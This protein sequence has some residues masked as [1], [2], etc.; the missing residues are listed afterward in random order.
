MS[1]TC[2]YTLWLDMINV[3]AIKDAG[4]DPDGY[5]FDQKLID[6]TQVFARCWPHVL[7]V[8][9]SEDWLSVTTPGAFSKM[10]RTI[11]STRVA[12]SKKS[13][14]D[15]RSTDLVDLPAFNLQGDLNWTQDDCDLFQWIRGLRYDRNALADRDGH[16]GLLK[17]LEY[18]VGVRFT[19]GQMMVNSHFH[20]A[21]DLLTTFA[22]TKS[23]TNIKSRYETLGVVAH[24]D[25]LLRYSSVF[26]AQLQLL[27]SFPL[28]VNE[29]IPSDVH[30]WDHTRLVQLQDFI[31]TGTW[32]SRFGTRSTDPPW[33]E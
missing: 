29:H 5:A 23:P 27:C 18:F 6:P 25:E 32:L 4:W 31:D 19:Q 11:V 15:L 30:G 26:A 22:V 2:A 21:L 13:D 33:R 9:T 24:R 16:F 28:L 20:S 10:V 7:E 1:I 14:F 3:P 17:L 12:S 8:M